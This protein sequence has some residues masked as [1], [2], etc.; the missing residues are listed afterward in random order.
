MAVYISIAAFALIVASIWLGHA[1]R[2]RLPEH[3]LS[4]DSKEV[5]RL[6]TA[7]IGTMAAV[8]LALLF[9]ST[10]ASYEQTNHNVAR[11]TAG[12]LE[13]D[14]LLSEYGGPDSLRLR[15]ALR[16]DVDFM[17]SS[18]WRDDAAPT[19]DLLRPVT[20]QESVLYRLRQLVPATPLQGSLQARAL[21]VSTGL[22]QVRLTLFAQP[23]DALSKPFIFVL[24]LW[25][26]FIFAT[27]SMSSRPNV[28]L[29]STLLACAMAASTAIYL[30]LELGQPFDGLLQISNQSLRAAL[31]PLS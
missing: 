18:I 5:I 27:F 20:Q 28:T 13:L 10:R 31:G 1:L 25:L 29:V 21:A 30:I 7:L 12:V 26:C 19:T 4:G 6:A 23:P 9:S 14:T 3:H 15:Q 22:D 16:A 8:V 24:V 2:R 17:I 11:L